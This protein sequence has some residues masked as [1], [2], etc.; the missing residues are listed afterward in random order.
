M[1]EGQDIILKTTTGL[2]FRVSTE[3]LGY[4]PLDD[5]GFQK[6]KKGDRVW[7]S[8]FWD[9]NYFEKSEID[10]DTLITLQKG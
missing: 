8:G 7:V 3:K 9:K 1:I 2:K 10:A 6:I 4:D 5:K